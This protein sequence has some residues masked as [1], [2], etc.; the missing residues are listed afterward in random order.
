MANVIIF[1]P[2]GEDVSAGEDALK[3]AGHEVSVIEATPANLLHVV[4][5]MVDSSPDENDKVDETPPGPAP[6]EEPEEE[7]EEL[8]VE[9]E[10]TTENLG[11]VVIDDIEVPAYL[12]RL[13]ILRVLQGQADSKRVNYQLK[14]EV[15]TDWTGAGKATVLVKGSKTA[16]VVAKVQRTNSCPHLVVS[17]A[18]AK[19]LGLI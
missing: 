14:E 8:P 13:S 9:D 7:T 15:V 1:A 17:E 4:I 16:T 19:K 6:E 12:G 3:E 5:G 18:D 10:L 2:K 11:T